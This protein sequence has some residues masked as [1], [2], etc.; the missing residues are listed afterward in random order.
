MAKLTLHIP[1]ELVT[2]AKSIAAD[3]KVSLS[4]LVTD[5]FQNL[6]N[7]KAF[8]ESDLQLA[9]RTRKLAG[10]IPNADMDDYID[11]LEKKHS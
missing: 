2:T 6:D 9:P 5:Y 8:E 10:C 4:K 1:Q 7:Q 3:R 11:Y